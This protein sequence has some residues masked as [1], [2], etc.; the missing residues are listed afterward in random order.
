MIELLPYPG[1]E[2]LR[3]FWTRE[4]IDKHCERE[5]HNS[6]RVREREAAS[7]GEDIEMGLCDCL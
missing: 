4:E 1:H 7:L 5:A 2:T 3:S 6:Q